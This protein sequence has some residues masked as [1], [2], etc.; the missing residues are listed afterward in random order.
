MFVL[1]YRNQDGGVK[2]FNGGTSLST[3]KNFYNQC[4]DSDLKRYAETRKLT[5]GQG[6]HYS[7]GC[8]MDYDYIKNH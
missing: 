5:I 1:L 8:L 6:E 4:I 3:E 2:K 7:M